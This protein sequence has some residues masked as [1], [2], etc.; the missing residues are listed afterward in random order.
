MIKIDKTYDFGYIHLFKSSNSKYILS[1]KSLPKLKKAI[2]VNVKAPSKDIKLYLIRFRYDLENKYP[3]RISVAPYFITEK[4]NLIPDS[5]EIA[6][7]IEYSSNELE[8]FGF[9]KE[10][11]N[12]I[13]NAIKNKKVSF[14]ELTE[15]ITNIL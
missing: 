11:I 5:E 12:K 10:H 9:K 8:K 1:E 7:T 14:K 13:I 2:K 15:S 6:L 3:L 4:L